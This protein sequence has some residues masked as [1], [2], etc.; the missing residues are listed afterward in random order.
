MN[1]ALFPKAL[2]V[3]AMLAFT[4]GIVTA[5]DQDGPAEELGEKIDDTL[6]DAANR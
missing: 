5:C 6:E 4:A 3:A 2:L 1:P